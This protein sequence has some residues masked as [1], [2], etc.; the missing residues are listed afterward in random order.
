[1]HQRLGVTEADP[2]HLSDDPDAR[3]H[4]QPGSAQPCKT[5]LQI[6]ALAQP[7]ARRTHGLLVSPV[8]GHLASLP[9]GRRLGW[10]SPARHRLGVAGLAG[11]V[12]AVDDGQFWALIAECRHQGINTDSVSRLLFRRLRALD[13]AD[14]VAFVEQWERTRSRLYSWPVADAACLLLGPV[15]E[16]DLR[17]IQDWVILHGQTTVDRVCRNSDDLAD[18]A[19]DRGAARAAWFAEFL[20]EA[21]V[22]VTGTWPLGHDPDGPEELTGEHQ[23]LSDHQVVERHYPRLAA[24]RRS[25]PEIGQPELR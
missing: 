9:R 10:P 16:E 5:C 20:T 12:P 2:E 4:A 1:M 23:D 24:F 7:T 21:Q 25:H 18:L 17:H 22:V 8:P 19:H 13:P 15:E 6:V 11:T 3:D 14:V